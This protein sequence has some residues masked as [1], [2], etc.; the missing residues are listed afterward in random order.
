[1]ASLVGTKEQDTSDKIEG[2]STK[3]CEDK[4]LPEIENHNLKLFEEDYQDE[5]KHV[6]TVSDHKEIN[7]SDSNAYYSFCESK[8]LAQKGENRDNLMTIS[9]SNLCA[10]TSPLNFSSP[11]SIIVNRSSNKHEGKLVLLQ[12][13]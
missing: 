9:K 11:S 7:K 6:R 2:E 8:K 3:W 10:I 4:T 1:M 12:K 13:K 5:N